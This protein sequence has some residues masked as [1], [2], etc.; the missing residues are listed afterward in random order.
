MGDQNPIVIASWRDNWEKLTTY[1]QYT[2]S[3]AMLSP[4]DSLTKTKGAFP[5]DMALLKLNGNE[6]YLPPRFKTGA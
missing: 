4:A 5:S 2:G 1:F 3:Q 6:E